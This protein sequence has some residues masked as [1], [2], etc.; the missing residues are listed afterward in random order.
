[1]S[2]LQI[3]RLGKADRGRMSPRIKHKSN[4]YPTI[5]GDLP[6]SSTNKNL[7]CKHTRGMGA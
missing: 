6:G 2:R 5:Q 1:M 3:E 4:V 7:L